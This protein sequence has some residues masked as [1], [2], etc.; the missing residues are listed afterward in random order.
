MN[1]SYPLAATAAHVST[2]AGNPPMYGMKTRGLPGTLAPMYQE[3]QVERS[4]PPA[5]L[6]RWLLMKV[7]AVA[8]LLARNRLLVPWSR[9][10][11]C[12]WPA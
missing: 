4:E 7:L 10:T 8:V 11:R 12:T 6:P 1:P 3:L 2:E 5:H 9:F